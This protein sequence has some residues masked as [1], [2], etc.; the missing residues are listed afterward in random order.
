[1]SHQRAERS[2]VK[3]H[4][5]QLLTASAKVFSEQGV[6]VSLDMVVQEAGLGKG[7]LYRH[8]PDRTALVIALF[9]R[10]TEAMF[11]HGDSLPPEQALLGMLRYLADAAGRA[12]ALADGWR[13]LPTD[14]PDY[15]AARARLIDRLW[16]PLKAAQHAD[17]VRPDVTA[18]DISLI[19]RLITIPLI[20][21]EGEPRGERTLELLLNGV[22]RTE[23]SA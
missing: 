15:A 23:P 2:D 10:E 6:H 14:H 11:R 19:I 22:Q 8:F 21:P 18:T 9:E 20:G 13:I 5:E 17:L 16:G 7:S 1:M 12:P 4:R 3:R